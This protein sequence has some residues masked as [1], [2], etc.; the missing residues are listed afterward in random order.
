MVRAK[1]KPSI[2]SVFVPAWGR[3]RVKVR[4]RGRG[5]VRVRVRFAREAC[6]SA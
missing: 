1:R 5:R 3:G 6:L 2:V 4:G